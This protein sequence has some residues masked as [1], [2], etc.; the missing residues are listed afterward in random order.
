MNLHT[1]FYE[2]AARY[3][4]SS[5]WRFPF[6]LSGYDERAVRFVMFCEKSTDEEPLND[7]VRRSTRGL[8]ML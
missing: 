8:V 6:V 2:T 4:S 7:K 5:K 1:G 3:V